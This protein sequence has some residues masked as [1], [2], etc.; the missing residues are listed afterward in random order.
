MRRFAMASII[1]ALILG[2]MAAYMLLSR[3]GTPMPGPL[4]PGQERPTYY[5]D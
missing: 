3:N 4:Q 1:A 5:G 2:G